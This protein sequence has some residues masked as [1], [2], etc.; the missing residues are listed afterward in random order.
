MQQISLLCY[1]KKIFNSDF[2]SH[3]ISRFI[4]VQRII[5]K[6]CHPQ[7][8]RVRR[9][10]YNGGN[11]VY[12]PYFPADQ[13]KRFADVH[14]VFGGSKVAKILKDVDAAHRE[15]AVNS[16]VYE[17]E[18]RLVDPVY[19]CVGL[20]SVMQNQL[21]VL[22]L[23][24]EDGKKELASLVRPTHY[25]NMGSGA[26]IGPYNMAQIMMPSGSGPGPVIIN[27]DPGHAQIQAQHSYHSLQLQQ[28][29]FHDH[30]HHGPTNE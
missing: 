23:S 11:C 17:A 3:L 9:E 13:P 24:L 29:V 6:K 12:A 2:I 1:R 5:I 28:H 26:S 14:M 27:S 20:I 7:T 25:Q 22:Q 18:A 30:R 16:L 15:E 19:G 8:R 10:N 21:K 4:E